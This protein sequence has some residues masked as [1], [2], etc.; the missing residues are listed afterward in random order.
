MDRLCTYYSDKRIDPPREEWTTDTP[1]G[2]DPKQLLSRAL[3]LWV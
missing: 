2:Y 3:C 1:P